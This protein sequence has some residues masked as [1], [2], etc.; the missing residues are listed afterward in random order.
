MIGLAEKQ[1]E[2]IRLIL[3]GVPGGFQKALAGTINRTL[4]AAR[5]ETDRGA[6]KIYDVSRA[7]MYA[8]SAIKI[9]RASGSDPDPSGSI[10]YSGVKI[11][12][13]RHR[14]EPP[15]PGTGETVR[16]RQTRAGT[17]A[18]F[19]HAFIATMGSGHTGIFERATR[20]RL[21]IEEIQGSSLA[22]MAGSEKVREGVEKRAAETAEARME[23]EIMRILEGY[24][25]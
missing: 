21:P 14:A 17:M 7:D 16:A 2:R 9:T 11:P 3:A 15:R 13:M 18:R 12:L 25:G 8:G 20:K 19:E 4:D 1:A 6:R 5:T 23:H 24:G 10:E 22:Q